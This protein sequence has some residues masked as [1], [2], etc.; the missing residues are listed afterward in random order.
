M[1]EK[2]LGSKFIGL[3]VENNGQTEEGDPHA[4][5]KPGGPKSAA[6]LV[7]ELAQQSGAK[8]ST[9]P[10]IASLPTS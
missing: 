6:D 9:R 8:P 3:F 10:L 2:G 7:A 4:P 1:S 5:G